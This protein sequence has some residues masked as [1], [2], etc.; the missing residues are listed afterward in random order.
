MKRIPTLL[1]AVL[2]APICIFGQ[3]AFEADSLRY[4]QELQE[5]RIP[6]LIEVRSDST[7]TLYASPYDSTVQV[8]QIAGL[9]LFL[10]GD[11]GGYWA[12]CYLGRLAYVRKSAAVN[13]EAIQR[14]YDSVSRH[15]RYLLAYNAVV[16]GLQLALEY[17][18]QATQ[19]VAQ[20]TVNEEPHIKSFLESQHRSL[21]DAMPY[22]SKTEPHAVFGM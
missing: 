14:A 17:T 15:Y 10:L 22:L 18:E 5:R 6:Q 13:T 16:Q 7:A 9:P 1:F 2:L 21:P 19:A 8:S 12:C 4:V 20:G 3:T 11:E